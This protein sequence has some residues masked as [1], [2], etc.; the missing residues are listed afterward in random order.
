MTFVWAK[1]TDAE[2]VDV[3]KPLLLSK[4]PYAEIAAMHGVTKNAVSGAVFRAKNGPTPYERVFDPVGDRHVDA[5]FIERWADRKKKPKTGQVTD[6]ETDRRVKYRWTP[7]MRALFRARFLARVPYKLIAHELGISI[8]AC[9]NMRRAMNLDVRN[10]PSGTRKYKEIS[11]GLSEKHYNMM[12]MRARALNLHIASYVRHLIEAD[13]EMETE[14][15]SEQL[16]GHSLT[17][18]TRER[19]RIGS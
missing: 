12:V 15:C 4:T 11:V 2:R 1:A 8:S 14:K 16:N 10:P 18:T 5:K 3:I 17:P 19:L 7:Q 9:K 6:P 13:Y